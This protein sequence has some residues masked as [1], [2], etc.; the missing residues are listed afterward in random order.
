MSA[1][2][3]STSEEGGCRFF[4]PCLSIAGGE[5]AAALREPSQAVKRTN[6][7]LR[8]PSREPSLMGRIGRCASRAFLRFHWK[9]DALIF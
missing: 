1:G 5:Q 4:A 8:E 7:A 9:P 6:K 2:R 3:Q